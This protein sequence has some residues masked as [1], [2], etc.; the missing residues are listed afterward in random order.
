M[1]DLLRKHVLKVAAALAVTIGM[2]GTASAAPGPSSISPTDNQ[3]INGIFGLNV[4]LNGWIEHNL[5]LIAG[6]NTTVSA[7]FMGSEATLNNTFSFGSFNPNTGGNTS[8]SGNWTA[9]SVVNITNV[10]P[11]L[12]PFSFTAP[13]Q[14]TVSNLGVNPAPN[15]GPNFFIMLGEANQ[16]TGPNR[17]AS[18]RIAYLF[19][20]DIGVLDDNH[21]DMVIRLSITDGTFAI[22]I[23]AAAWLMIA[24][25][26]GLGLVARRRK[27]PDA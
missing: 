10:A 14:G 9:G 5:Y 17:L 21:D 8:P 26:G 20:D 22:P 4:P 16:N 19:L 25:I 15:V 27:T 24:G 23:P 2:A 12:L 11:G 1:S 18:S 6:T 3:A 7:Q 13:G